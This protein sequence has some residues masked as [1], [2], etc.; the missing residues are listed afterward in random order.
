MKTT[1][2]I[3]RAL[4][5]FAL[6]FGLAALSFGQ[7]HYK[8]LQYG[9]L[10]D[11]AIPQPKQVTLKNG[12][13]LFLL[14]DHDLPFVK[15]E[16]RY[17]AGSAWE[18]AEKAGLAGIT[19]MVMRTGGSQSMPGDQIDEEL[20][21]IAA[22]VETGIGQLEGS[23]GLSTLKDHFDKVLAIYADVLLHPA[24][25]PEKIELAKIEYK[26]GISRRNDQVGQIAQREFSQLIYGSD[27]PYTRDEEYAT[28]DAITRDD[29]IAY[30]KQ[31]VQP[32]GM[33]L[34]VWGDFKSDAML[35]KLRKTFE[36]WKGTGGAVPKAPAVEYA[37]RR[38]VN[39]VPKTDVNQSNIWLGHIGGLKN[40]PDEAALVMM[41]E[42]LS[43]GFSSR[44]FNRLRATEGL[45]YSVF[46]AYGTNAL[47]PG[48]FYMGLQTQSGRTVEAI[49]SLV[50]EMR[51]MA[52]EPVTDEELRYARESWLNSYVFNFDSKDEIIRRMATYA[53]YGLPLDYLQKLRQQIE[54]VKKEDVLA[55]AK[56]YLRPEE[57]QILV[58]GNPAEFGEPL[59]SLG[60]VQEI[61]IAIPMPGGAAVPEATAESKS[62]GRTAITRMM[63][64]M[65]GADKL[66]AVKNV[67][68]TLKLVQVTPMGDMAMDARVINLY[69]DKTCSIIKLP[70][71]E[72]KMILNGESGLMVSPQGSM[73]APE[74]V[75]QNMIENL[76]RDPI[77]LAKQ[78]DAVEVQWVGETTYLDKPAA[79]LV[80]AKGKL[81]YRLFLDG[82]SWLPLGIKY[83]TVG[84]QGPTE[85]EERYED[86]REVSGIKAAFKTLGYEKETKASESNII[87]M[88][89]DGPVDLTV[90]EK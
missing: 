40:T 79:E 87:E 86:Y 6:M 1:T 38:S 65:G 44:L 17:V 25:P 30:H 20:E 62:Q 9:K 67:E 83:T 74:P 48:V 89:V 2:R 72:I 69:P 50:R 41:N 12:I 5:L 60:A 14:E 11:V 88:T 33:V 70:M 54:L 73:P 68:Y 19:G 90:F 4:V 32:K 34:A 24:F 78:L 56:K 31:Y 80:V 3:F 85:A 21:K 52:S 76:F 58:V 8:E 26:S 46:G 42:I 35:V 63:T 37:Y 51:L 18:P 7:K 84:Q 64:A 47:Y 39:L 43:G 77:M 53:Y 36:G 61:D 23:A 13:R 66:A 49:N 28:I 55:A 27:S 75:K 59:T 10:N 22:S 82:A 29:L 57:V 81:N 16:A 71:G 45:A 15:M